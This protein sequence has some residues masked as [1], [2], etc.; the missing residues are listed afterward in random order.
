MPARDTS[1]FHPE[2]QLSPN[3]RKGLQLVATPDRH[4][5]LPGVW[6]MQYSMVLT[7][8]P[9]SEFEKATR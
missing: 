5:N 4:H 6:V 8:A 7:R 3:P 9:W 1:T 2:L